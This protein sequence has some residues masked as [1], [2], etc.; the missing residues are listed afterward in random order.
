MGIDRAWFGSL[1]LA[2]AVGVPAPARAQSG[3]GVHHTPAEQAARL[4]A[5]APA[6]SDSLRRIVRSLDVPT[7]E[8]AP[9]A[10]RINVELQVFGQATPAAILDD[11]DVGIGAPVYG[12]PTHDEM[13]TIVTPA[14]F[15]STGA[16]RRLRPAVSLTR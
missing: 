15:R 4:P 3:E 9:A 10:L 16:W 11:V 13:I 5:A 2:A 1:V 7:R 6:A 12:A 14:P 8:A